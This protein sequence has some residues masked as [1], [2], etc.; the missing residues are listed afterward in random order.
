MGAMAAG[1]RRSSRHDERRG[2]LL[3]AAAQMINAL[4]AGAINLNDIA[5]RI[6]LSRNALYYYVKDRNELVFECY[7]Q[8]CEAALADVADATA[9]S[10]QAAEQLRRFIALGLA[11]DR[12]VTAVLSDHDMLPEPQRRIIIDL[13]RRQIDGLTSI[14]ASGIARQHFRHCDAELV[15]QSLVGMLSWTQLSADWLAHRDGPEQR[16]QA[17]R[18]MQALLMDGLATP[19]E[20]LPT[21]PTLFPQAFNAFDRQAAADAKAE[22]LIAAASRL[23]N[24]RGIAGVSLDDI[25]ASVGATKGAVYHYFPDKTALVERCLER[26]FGLYDEY[27]A[28]AMRQQPKGLARALTVHHLNAQAQAGPIAPMLLQPGYDSLSSAARKRFTDRAQ[29][30]WQATAGL[31]E[32][33]ITDGS[34]RPC[35]AMAL[36]EVAAGAF[37]WLPKW[38]P[39][40]DTAAAVAIADTLADIVAFGIAAP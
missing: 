3:A 15:A 30:L 37:F 24:Q 18:A 7:R 23:F 5:A 6:G 19:G 11:H 36:A 17:A 22:Q 8:T 38:R 39:I 16:Q 9:C 32:T 31:I 40:G 35:D 26:A 21:F 25:G 27:M 29:R 33:G 14:I 20:Q 1:S 2:A 13:R 10:D 28:I 12:P 4:G 34:C